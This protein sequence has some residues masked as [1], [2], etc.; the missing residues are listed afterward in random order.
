MDIIVFND[1]TKAG[2]GFEVDT[3][4]VVIIDRKKE[5]KLPLLSKDSVADEILNRLVELKA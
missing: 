2:S 1:V 3:N 4:K 5:L